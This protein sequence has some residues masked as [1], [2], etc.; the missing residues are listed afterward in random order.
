MDTTCGLGQLVISAPPGVQVKVT[1]TLVWFQPAALGAGE[2]VAEIAGGPAAVTVRIV[3]NANP[4]AVAETLVLPLPT[5]AARPPPLIVATLEFADAQATEAVTSRVL[6][7][8][9]LPTAMNCWFT[10]NGSTGFCGLR[11]AVKSAGGATARFADA[12]TLPELAV[13][14]VA[15]WVREVTNPAELIVATARAD[16]LQV[17]VLVRSFVLPSAKV[18]VAV[19]DSVR[20]KG[21]EGVAGLM[22]MDANGAVTFKEAE[23]LI[24]LK[25]AVIV[26][27][28]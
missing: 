3:V 9:N 7:S 4:L 24:P 8:E 26:L 6:P 15:P 14:V 21:T 25:L 10:P 18:P 16:E 20:P 17:T 19:S 11:V 5:V 27:V 2:I 1:V 13:I 12:V 28:P 22:A 23:E